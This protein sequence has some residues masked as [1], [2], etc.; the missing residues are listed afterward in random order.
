MLD[1]AALFSAY[2]GEGEARL[3]G[4]FARA[5][6]AAPAILFIDEIDALGGR[7]EAGDGGDGG[8]AGA[9]LLSA[10][11]TE[12]DGLELATG[13]APPPGGLRA[14]GVRVGAP[15]RTRERCLGQR[16][17]AWCHRVA[18]PV[19]ELGLCRRS[20]P[21]SQEPPGRRSGARGIWRPARALQAPLHLGPA[22]GDVVL[23]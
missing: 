3:R 7:R 22:P 1:G 12:M 21:P 18:A 4:A 8:G 17:E 23:A 16:R 2:V 10:L 9:R 14:A 5:R 20:C 15:C 11:L 19:S 13:A 6:Q